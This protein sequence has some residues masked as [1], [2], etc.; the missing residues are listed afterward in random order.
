GDDRFGLAGTVEHVQFALHHADD[1]F[2]GGAEIVAG[3][4][5][6]GLGGEDFADFGGHG[7][8]Q[9]GVDVHLAHAVFLHG[10]GDLVL[11]HALGVGHSAAVFVDQVDEFL[12]DRRAAVHNQGQA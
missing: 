7:Q 2:A 4:E 9:V 3:V 6:G 12:G 11:R 8:A 1:R 5:F 10:H